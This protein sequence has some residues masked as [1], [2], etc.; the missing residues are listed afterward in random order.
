MHQNRPILSNQAAPKRSLHPGGKGRQLLQIARA[1]LNVPPFLILPCEMV[2][3]IL[4]P[5]RP[6]IEQLLSNI[7]GLEDPMLYSATQQ[8]EALIDTIQLSGDLL[9]EILLNCKT[10]FGTGYLVAIRSSA[11]SED[12]SNASFA[13]QHKSFLG[14]PADQLPAKIR[15][16]IASAWSF[17]ALSYRLAR[18]I[19]FRQ[20]HYAVI[21][22]QMV[23]SARSGIA[24]S[25]D[26]NGNLANAIIVGGYGLG[27]GIVQDQ[28]ETDSYT[29]DRRHRSV[30]KTIGHK[31]TRIVHDPKRGLILAAVPEAEQERPVFQEG[32]ILQ[33]FNLVMQAEKLLGKPADIEFAFDE[34]GKLFLLQMRP[35]TTIDLKNIEI[36]DNTN[37]V[38]SYPEITLPLSFSF[39]RSAYEK[40][41][42][43]SSGAFWI[44]EKTMQENRKVFQHLLAH[45]SG[46]IYY[47]LDNWYRM[48]SLVYSSPKSIAAWEKAVGLEYSEKEKVS[49]RFQSKLKTLLAFLWMILNY[50]RGNRRFFRLFDENYQRLKDF[51]EHIHHP[52]SLWQHYESATARLFR[53]WYLTL[54]NDF[55]AFKFF[56]WLQDMIKALNIKESD[57]LANDLLCGI[58]GIASEAAVLNVLTL[59]EMILSDPAL[60]ALFQMPEEQILFRLKEGDFADFM[61]HFQY[62]LQHYGDRTLAELKLETPSFRTEPTAFVK[63][64]KNQLASSVN[65][66]SFTARQQ[67]IRTQAET[68][69]RV[70]LK[71]WHPQTWIFHFVR[72]MAAYGLKNRENMRFCRTRGYGIVKDI[73]RAIGKMMVRTNVIAEEADVFY[74]SL[75]DLQA[76][77]RDQDNSSRQDKIEKLKQEYTNFK[78]RSPPGRVIYLSGALPAVSKQQAVIVSHNGPYHGLAVSKGTV[79]GPAAILLHPEPHTSVHGKIL[80]SKMTDPGWVF[81]MMQAAGLVSEQ[82]SLLSHTAIVGRE[83]GI[84]V[85][86]GIKDAT[87][88]F[89]EGEWLVLDGGAG[90]VERYVPDKADSA[91]D[92]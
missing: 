24:F 85:V 12:G 81:L 77:C 50:R 83:L 51:Q 68:K 10:L 11:L 53:P 55:L 65:T 2:D 56:G 54:V 16:C 27:E 91:C 49:F 32:E 26:Q 82:G 42:T 43:G 35:I 31:T 86:V 88:I 74:L 52:A 28:V 1:N 61:I 59:K 13:G 58:G 48:V 57:T 76:F 39:A 6:Q 63:L 23:G 25:M 34:R 64:L 37:I 9:E 3:E 30:S 46:R 22:Q 4:L 15:A 70:A 21:I 18:G 8:I 44:S 33:V 90:R 89:K 41:F 66:Q 60:T 87:T 84:P 62:H 73:F 29:V 7:K 92:R 14:V 40:V 79:S 75:S 5:V 72:R 19:S 67:A 20:I 36:L 71:W 17:G 78:M 38:E 47:R 80:V 45:Y 69:L